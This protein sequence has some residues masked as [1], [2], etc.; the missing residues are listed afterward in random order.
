MDKNKA[1]KTNTVRVEVTPAVIR[2]ALERSN[3]PSGIN[4]KFP[5]LNEW[6]KGESSPTLRQLEQLAKATYTPL[7]Y[8]FLPEPPAEEQLPIPYFR[9]ID[10]VPAEPSLN[11]VETVQT[12]IHRQAWMREYLIELGQ[13]PLPFVHSIRLID[14]LNIVQ[15]A[16]KIKDTLGLQEGWAADQ[17]TWTAALRELQKRAEAAGIIVVVNSVVGN[18]THRKLDP[19]EFR[20]FVLIDNYAPLVFL[21]SA[22]GKAAQMFTLAHELA[23]VWVGTS[24]V[25]DLSELHPANDKV[26]KICN[27]IAAEFLV[28]EEE[29]RRIWPSVRQEPDKFQLLARQFK[30]SE[31]VIAR[32]TLDLRFIT[33]EIFLDFYRKYQERERQATQD[34]TGGG[35]FYATQNMRIGQRFAEAVVCAVREGRLLYSEAYE[36]TGLRG[37]IFERYARKLHL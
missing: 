20:G 32:R 30:V 1:P 15:M 8:F 13:D 24:A 34:D 31:L 23:H 33:K 14:N 5:R 25:F 11:L 21:N 17:R 4:Q 16:Q 35:D 36:L 7:G 28:P 19:S 10:S 18:N 9:T 6:I 29:L 12:M 2:W 37:E 27:Q 26:E 3:M 22:D